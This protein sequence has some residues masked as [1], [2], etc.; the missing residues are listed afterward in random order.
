MSSPSG[1]DALPWLCTH[2]KLQWHYCPQFPACRAQCSR[3]G[4][5]ALDGP[6]RMCTSRFP[7]VNRFADQTV[8]RAELP[9]GG[10]MSA[11]QIRPATSGTH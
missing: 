8:D 11:G 7:T 5:H 1:H 6:D 4:V 2:D 3:S 10:P 9:S